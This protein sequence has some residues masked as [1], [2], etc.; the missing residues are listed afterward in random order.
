MFK[1]WVQSETLVTQAGPHTCGVSAHV[2]SH[3]VYTD[4]MRGGKAGPG[5]TG[6]VIE[7]VALSR[8]WKGADRRPSAPGTIVDQPQGKAKFNLPTCWEDGFQQHR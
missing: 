7:G 8:H 6:V 5:L 2:A 4:H 1:V 3:G